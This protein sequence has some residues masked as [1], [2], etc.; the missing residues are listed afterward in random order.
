MGLELASVYL[1][2]AGTQLSERR[3]D[4]EPRARNGELKSRSGLVYW[5]FVSPK[6]KI[7]MI[8]YGVLS[9]YGSRHF[10]HVENIY[11]RSHDTKLA[12]IN[13]NAFLLTHNIYLLRLSILH[14][15]TIRLLLRNRLLT[16]NSR[17]LRRNSLLQ[18]R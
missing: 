3:R 10:K 6:A 2:G 16:P 5:R 8:A 14:P 17:L 9:E 13:S 1:P 12:D 7:N 18:R 11:R 4:S 15:L